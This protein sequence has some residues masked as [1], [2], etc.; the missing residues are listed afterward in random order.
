LLLYLYIIPEV[1][2][3]KLVDI[4]NCLDKVTCLVR[5]AKRYQ[6]MIKKDQTISSAH[7]ALPG[8]IKIL[9]FI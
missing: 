7:F 8:I 4:A 3:N 1:K 9:V 6:G 5:K 2:R